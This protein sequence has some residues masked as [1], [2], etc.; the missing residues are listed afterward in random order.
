MYVEFGIKCEF[1]TPYSPNFNPIEES[2][3]ELK[4]WI[5]KNRSIVDCKDFQQFLTLGLDY[6]SRKVGN[7]F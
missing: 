4:Q 1:L 2:F 6:I 3:T 7:H 5:K